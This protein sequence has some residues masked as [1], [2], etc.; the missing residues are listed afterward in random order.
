M[1][2]AVRPRWFR[3]WH[4]SS[5]NIPLYIL[6][7]LRDWA[8]R[9]TGSGKGSFKS[10]PVFFFVDLMTAHQASKAI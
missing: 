8:S 6:I 4:S 3:V 9:H 5:Q 2:C 10:I 1:G 7:L